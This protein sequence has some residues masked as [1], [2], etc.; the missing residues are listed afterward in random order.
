MTEAAAQTQEATKAATAA[1]NDATK[2]AAESLK[3]INEATKP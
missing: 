1:L 3:A 2:N